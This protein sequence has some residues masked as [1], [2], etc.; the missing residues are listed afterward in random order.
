VDP[1]AV[2]QA[3]QATRAADTAKVKVRVATSGF[4]LPVPVKVDG[5][6]TTALSEPE[7]DLTLDL[8]PALRLLGRGGDGTVRVKVDGKDVAVDPPDV[9]GFAVPDGADWLRLDLERTIAAMGIDARGLGEI[10]TIDPGAQLDVLRTAGDVEDLGDTTVGGARTT[11]YRGTVRVEDFI[12]ELPAERR[13]AARKAL[14]ALEAQTETADDA[15]PFD[16]WVD[17]RDR[18]RRMEQ[19]VAVPGQQ[20]LPSGEVTITMELSGFGAR[21]AATAPPRA[22]TYDVTA[23]VTRALRAQR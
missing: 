18:I 2:A 8:G 9:E 12:D 3:A 11:H 20:G 5:E 19:R 21:L 14:D 4:G 1:A 7:M 10:L 6:G 22:D 17:E 15:A 13:A 16:V 23:D